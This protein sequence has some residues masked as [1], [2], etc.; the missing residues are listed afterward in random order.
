MQILKARR[1]KF[2]SMVQLRNEKKGRFQRLSG[3]LAEGRRDLEQ[4]TFQLQ[5]EWI[6]LD[7]AFHEL[8]ISSESAS[9]D[10]G[11]LLDFE[12]TSTYYREKIL[13]L[14]DREMQLK[15]EQR[16]VFEAEESDTSIN[17]RELFLNLEMLLRM[18]QGASS[19]ESKEVIIAGNSTRMKIPEITV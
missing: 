14:K 4:E 13:E 10:L 18:K 8:R 6:E 15:D 11:E 17:Q 19:S 16:R 2:R 7:G 9:K 3:R 12:N 5:D 1:E